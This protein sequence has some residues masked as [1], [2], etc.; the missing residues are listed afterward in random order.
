[1]KKRDRFPSLEGTKKPTSVEGDYNCFTI[2]PFHHI[3]ISTCEHGF[4]FCALF[5]YS[6]LPIHFTISPFHHVNLGMYYLR[7]FAIFVSPYLCT[8]PFHRLDIS[9]FHCYTTISHQRYIRKRHH[10]S[11]PSNYLAPVFWMK[12]VV[13]KM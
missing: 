9:P 3:S 1:M 12:V 5:H 7:H 2:T 8:N 11:E 6:S 13:I 10:S 4:V